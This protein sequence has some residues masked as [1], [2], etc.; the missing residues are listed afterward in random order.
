MKQQEIFRK[1][2]LERLS[3]PEQ[4]DRLVTLT[5]P[6]GWLALLTL[7]AL[8][9]GVVVWGI[10]GSIPTRVQGHGI[11]INQGGRVFDAMAQAN[12][13]LL[14]VT[15]ELGDVVKKDQVVAK[16]DQS[17]LQQQHQHAQTVLQER[18]LEHRQLKKAFAQELSIKKKNFKKQRNS[19]RKLIRVAQ[20]RLKF[21]EKTL[22]LMEQKKGYISRLDVEQ[23]REKYHATVQEILRSEN[24]ILKLEA[25]EID[26][27]HRQ[28]QELT[29]S[30]FRLNE[31]K[32]KVEKL[33]LQLSQSS[34]VISP[35]NGRVTEVKAASGTVISVGTPIISLESA[36]DNLQLILYI[37]PVYGKQ[38]KPSME[39]R[40]APAPVKKEEF[41]TLVGE[42]VD[43]SEFPATPSGMASVLPNVRLVQQF[44][45][46]GP[47]YAARVNLIPD[48][49]T[50]S[51][52]KWSSGK[53][54]EMTLTSGTLAT[55]EVTVK[56]QAPISLVIPYFREYTGIGL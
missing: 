19:L 43:I 37:P 3:S 8:L 30:S 46:Q 9:A 50:P 56:E 13:M 20:Q 39:V 51:G 48:R 34:A 42:I 41:G 6:Q 2:A 15:V 36:G 38:I 16:I 5:S 35:D 44:S 24:E 54:P 55:A 11:L 31:A 45:Q 18:T 53:G 29:R 27:K 1:A 4:L 22:K 33:A 28:Q 40:I 14:A 7:C 25:E 17:D 23:L 21:Q 10:Y 26:L 52:Y 12:G 49:R 32:R 47:P